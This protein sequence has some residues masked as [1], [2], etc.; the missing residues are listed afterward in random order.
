MVELSLLVFLAG[1]LYAL[2]F[3]ILA[4]IYKIFGKKELQLIC[5]VYCLIFAAVS[6]MLSESLTLAYVIRVFYYQ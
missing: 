4:G 6:T 5:S 3:F 2:A 1:V